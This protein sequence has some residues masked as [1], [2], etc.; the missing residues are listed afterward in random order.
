MC[1][2]IAYF[3]F[4]ICSRLFF[5]LGGVVYCLCSRK[6]LR[7]QFWGIGSG[8]GGVFG[9]WVVWRWCGVSGCVFAYACMCV[10]VCVGVPACALRG[11][12]A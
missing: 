2:K 4:F 5:L 3:G 8:Y 1:Y 10:R 6:R 7:A 11:L 12:F 9:G